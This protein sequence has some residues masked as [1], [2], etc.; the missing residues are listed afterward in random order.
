M[1]GKSGEI[2]DKS[3]WAAL[4][5]A[6]SLKD[7]GKDTKMPHHIL[8]RIKVLR[9]IKEIIQEIMEQGTR[10]IINQ[11]KALHDGVLWGWLCEKLNCWDYKRLGLRATREYNMFSA[12]CS[13]VA[14]V[15][16]EAY[17]QTTRVFFHA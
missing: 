9:L 15:L 16:P 13:S 7:P 8:K 6:D 10:I 17:A 4:G 5:N 1:Q 3:D 14:I 2:L 11:A 12:P